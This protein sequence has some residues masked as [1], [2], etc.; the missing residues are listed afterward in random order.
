MRSKLY[1]MNLVMSG[2]VSGG[3]V[4]LIFT[5]LFGNI[6]QVQVALAACFFIAGS[7]LLVGSAKQLFFHR[8]TDSSCEP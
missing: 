7:A 5:S 6:E 1:N 4:S 3:I 2:F 8:E